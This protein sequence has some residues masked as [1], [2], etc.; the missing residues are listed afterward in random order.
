MSSYKQQQF[1]EYTVLDEQRFKLWLQRLENSF[2]VS[3]VRT[4]RY[5][6]AWRPSYLSDTPPHLWIS[7]VLLKYRIVELSTSVQCG[8]LLRVDGGGPEGGA[9]RSHRES[10]REGHPELPQLGDPA[11]EH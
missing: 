7:Y 3:Y 2:K 1:P 4:L 11:E 8:L 10:Y 5:Y 6:I 9:A